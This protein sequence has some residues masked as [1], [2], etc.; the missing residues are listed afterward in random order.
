[1]DVIIMYVYM[2]MDKEKL[3][4]LSL[5]SPVPAAGKLGPWLPWPA[6]PAAKQRGAAMMTSTLWW[7]HNIQIGQ[8][9]A[10]SSLLRVLFPLKTLRQALVFKQVVSTLKCLLAMILTFGFKIKVNCFKLKPNWSG[11]KPRCLYVH[12]FTRRRHLQTDI[13]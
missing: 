8:Q 6:S 11:D 5:Q 1:M 10:P 13:F 9:A 2:C 4:H 7:I 3:Y 12:A